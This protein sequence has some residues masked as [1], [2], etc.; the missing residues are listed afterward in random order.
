[1]V[2][3]SNCKVEIVGYGKLVHLVDELNEGGFAVKANNGQLLLLNIY[4]HL[5]DG[6]SEMEPVLAN[7]KQI[8]SN[9]QKLLEGQEK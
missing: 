3:V 1:M 5:P 7:F 2:P 9:Y 8:T 6:K 4:L